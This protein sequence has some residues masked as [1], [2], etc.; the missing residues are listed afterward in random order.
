VRVF[1]AGRG[2]VAPLLRAGRHHRRPGSGLTGTKAL[3][4]LGVGEA[5]AFSSGDD[6]PLLIR[7]PLAKNPL[8]TT[9]PRDAQVAT[10]MAQWR[11]SQPIQALFLPQPFCVHTCADAQD[12]CAAARRLTADGYVQ[13]TVART[14]LSTIEEPGALD[15]LWDDLVGVVGARRPTW[16]RPSCGERSP[17]TV[18]W[19]AQRRGA[20]G[21]WSYIDTN[22]FGDQLRA[23]LL[24]K[25]Q[26]KTP[27]ARPICGPVPQQRPGATCAHVSAVSGVGAG[28]PARPAIV[29]VPGCGG[30]P[31]R[32]RSIPTV[33]AG[34]DVADAT[35]A[36]NRRGQTWDVCQDAAYEITEKKLRIT[37]DK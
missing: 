35:S 3:T 6:S 37:L 21:T 27:A 34:P 32:Q 13:R 9:P 2:T 28:V 29:P 17:A 25:R 14:V 8:S 33:L 4:T 11:A 30:R 23:V 15:R 22:Q 10:H 1:T 20:H 5:I 19:Y 31:G 16:T 26:D 12:E 36:D 18:D 24:D 7:V